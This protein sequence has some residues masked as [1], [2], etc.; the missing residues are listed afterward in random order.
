MDKRTV[1]A[2]VSHRGDFAGMAGPVPV[3]EPWWSETRSVTAAL[4]ELTRARTVVVRII[5]APKGRSMHGGE[6]T[7]H[8][9]AL[10]W[11]HNLDTTPRPEWDDVVRPH[12]LR[13]PWATVAG[14]HDLLA[15]ATDGV[16]L[17]EP[18]IQVK[19]WNLSCVFHLHTTTGQLWAKATPAF[20]NSEAAIIESVAGH[21]PDLVPRIRKAD[22]DRHRTLLEHLPGEDCFT[23][24]TEIACEVVRRWVAVQAKITDPALP[25]PDPLRN[26][27]DEL[28]EHLPRLI[29]EVDAAGLPTTL[30]HGDF[31]PG[32][33]RSDGVHHAILDWADS[34]AGNP[35]SD[36][37][38]LTGWLP[39]AQR[40]PVLAA[41][42][43]AWRTHRP[44]C[45]PL[46]A[47]AGMRVIGHVVAAGTYQRFLDN[48]EPAERGYH[49]GDPAQ[50]LRLALEN[51]GWYVQKAGTE[52][53]DPGRG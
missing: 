46:R 44:G 4:D 35:A 18:P 5:D 8:V 12:P 30:V 7:Y 53:A 1:R 26:A 45:E 9:E 36:I 49:D 20:G 11:P 33:W 22:V 10:T 51:L 34:Y 24:S 3:A 43:E 50:Q 39:E 17:T 29:E 31:H 28:L 19:S 6:V 47:L 23:V 15:W 52:R 41:W 14:V 48:I 27:P 37:L 32:N 40:E 21:D 25:R 38:R 16:E 2:Y 42:A 13:T